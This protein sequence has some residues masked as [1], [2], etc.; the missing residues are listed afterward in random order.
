MTKLSLLLRFFA[1]VILVDVRFDV[2]TTF[3]VDIAVIHVGYIQLNTV[4]K[5]VPHFFQFV[6]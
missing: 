4:R 2:E 5:K 6:R 3:D 1:A